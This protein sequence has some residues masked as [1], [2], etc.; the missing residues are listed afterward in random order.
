MLNIDIH[1]PLTGF[2]LTINEHLK[3]DGITGIFGHS[4]A[5]KTTLLRAIAGLNKET[6]GTI[7]LDDVSWLDSHNNCFVSPEHRQVSMVF[8]EARLFP[9]LTI[10]Q[11]LRYAQ[12]RCKDAN[13]HYSELIETM[14]I[15][16]LL[17]KEITTLSG[18]EK[19][20]VALARA[21]LSEPKLLLLDEPLSALDSG[22][23]KQFLALLR[24][25]H[26]KYHIPM[27][28]VSHQIAEIQQL[29]DEMIVLD[30]GKVTHFGKTADVIYTL[31]DLG[32]IR[33]QTSLDLVINKHLSDYGITEL[34]LA[35]SQKL[36]L[37]THHLNHEQQQR[38]RCTVMS[39]DISISVQSPEST[40]IMNVVPVVITKIIK[41]KNKAKVQVGYK[42]QTFFV[43]ISLYSLFTLG[44][45]LQQHVFIQFKASA[46]KTI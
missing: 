11:N 42:N 14:G 12:V 29:T 1:S 2:D 31:S 10:A 39:T 13:I 32:D 37:P 8:Q 34:L 21:I 5:G 26:K 41:L 23:R 38:V 7:K 15:K 17:N 3:S 9:H 16:P 19:Q 18:G 6:R 28:F 30:H 24:Q 45:S 4:G 27:I 25:I 22:S 46:L 33:E 43:T 44:L 35:N 40:S 36:Y 20:R